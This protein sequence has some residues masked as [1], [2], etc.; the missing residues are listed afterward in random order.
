MTSDSKRM[1]DLT[2][3]YARARA[4]AEK[5]MTAKEF[6]K[7]EHTLT[8]N[9]HARLYEC[10]LEGMAPIKFRTPERASS[11]RRGVRDNLTQI[12]LYT[13][14]AKVPYLTLKVPSHI[15]QQAGKEGDWIEWRFVRGRII[16]KKVTTEDEAEETQET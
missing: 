13:G 16:G 6:A 1:D 3:F 5:G 11:R 9:I 4:A 15:V 12:T 14:R 2:S 8:N 10:V 7:Q